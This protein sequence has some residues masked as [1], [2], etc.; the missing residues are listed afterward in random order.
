MNELLEVNNK[1]ERLNSEDSK[2]CCTNLRDEIK[3]LKEEMSSKN[4]IIKI[5]AENTYKSGNSKSSNCP[6]RCGNF[7]NLNSRCSDRLRSP[8]QN[9]V[10]NLRNP[11]SEGNGIDFQISTSN[12]FNHLTVDEP[13]GE[14]VGQVGQLHAANRPNKKS[15]SSPKNLKRRPPTVINKKP[16]NHDDFQR[17]KHHAANDRNIHHEESRLRNRRK[18]K[19]IIMFSDSIPK[20][21]RIREF[22]CYITNATARLKCFPGATSK[23]LTHYVVPTLQEESFNSALIQIGINDILK[24][25]SDLQFGLLLRNIV[26][27]PQRCKDHSIEEIIIS[28]L[29]V[30]ERID[31]NLLARAN[32]PLCSICRVNGFYLVDNSNISVDNLFK[33]K[34]YLL[35]SGKTILVNNFIYCINNYF[36][37]TRTH[38]PHF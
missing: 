31:P 11:V 37:Y 5:L 1:I 7:Q 8:L 28:S 36:L 18:I 15:A 30:T 2:N 23:E 4:L 3:Y 29:I 20:G 21:S 17:V 32:A 38:H 22:N 25:Q 13:S 10:V 9:D 34:L 35:D 24:D 6:C 16:E 26:E 14:E 33:H 12:R 19:R 27:I